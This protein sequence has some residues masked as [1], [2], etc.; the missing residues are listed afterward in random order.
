MLFVFF[1]QI[2]F[3]LVAG[4]F[5]AVAKMNGDVCDHHEQ[6]IETNMGSRNVTINVRKMKHKYMLPWS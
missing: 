4:V 5:L 3:C 1:T 2:L 6:L